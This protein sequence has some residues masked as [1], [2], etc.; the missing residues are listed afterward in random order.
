MLGLGLVQK[1]EVQ[2]E[3]LCNHERFYF[4]VMAGKENC[5]VNLKVGPG[6]GGQA[7]GHLARAPEGVEGQGP[8]EAVRGLEVLYVVFRILIFSLVF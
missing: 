6:W 2:R 4:G 7:V 8:A 5:K 3:V 1:H